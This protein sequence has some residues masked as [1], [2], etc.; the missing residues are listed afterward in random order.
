MGERWTLAEIPGLTAVTALYA[1]PNSD[2]RLIARSAAGLYLST[3]YGDHWA[4]LPFPLPVSD[5]NA[6]AIPSDETAPLLVATRVGLYSSPDGGNKWFANLGGLPASTVTAVLYTGSERAA[7]AVEY[8][9]LF[10]T[11]NGGNSWSSVSTALPPLTIR[12]LW[13]PPGDS[14]R[15]YGI[16]S[17]LGIIFR[18]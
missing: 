10:S 14:K 3:D 18:N 1:S 7:Y 2:G 16:T 15:L 8:G 6:I 12:Q 11:A 5:V 9:R 13:M 4:L 17:D